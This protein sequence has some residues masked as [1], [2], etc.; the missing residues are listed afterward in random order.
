LTL[1][2]VNEQEPDYTCSSCG[3]GRPEIA[4]ILTHDNNLAISF[5]CATRAVEAFGEHFGPPDY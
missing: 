1:A 3:R 5:E 4:K 2:L